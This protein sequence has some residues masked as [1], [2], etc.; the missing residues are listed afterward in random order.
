MDS[1]AS[2]LNTKCRAIRIP[3]RFIPEIL[4]YILLSFGY[5]KAIFTVPN[6]HACMF[7]RN[8]LCI[9][10]NLFY[11]WVNSSTIGIVLSSGAKVLSLEAK[12]GALVWDKSLY[13]RGHENH[14]KECIQEEIN[15]KAYKGGDAGVICE[16]AKG[17]FKLNWGQT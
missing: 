5:T 14:V 3:I 7:L 10:L 9:M 12:P 17:S 15:V 2:I 13:C 4:K 16:D 1:L 8:W 6:I 11:S